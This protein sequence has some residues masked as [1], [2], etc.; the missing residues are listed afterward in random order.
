MTVLAALVRAYD[1]LAD[2]GLAPR[3][4]YSVQKIAYIIPLN[5]D[6]TVAGGPID[7]RVM[8]KRKLVAR[9]MAVPQPPK[10]TSGIAPNFLWDKTAYV[11]G[12]TAG[13]GKRLAAEH[14][15]FVSCHLDALADST[16]EGLV[17]LRRF[18]QAWQPDDFARLGWPEEMKDQN[19]AFALESERRETMI[20][21]RKAAQELWAR[22]Q[23]A[24]SNES[25][26]CLVTG[27]RAPVARLHPAIKGVWGAQ[28]SGASLVS[29][30]LDAFT[31]YGHEQ[32]DNAPVSEAAAFAYTTALNRFL[33]QGST[34]RLQVGDASTVFWAEAATREAAADAEDAF[35]A[36]MGAERVDEAAEGK[37]VGDM[38]ALIRSGQKLSALRPDLAEGVRFHV[39]G[40]APNAARL[41]VRFWLDDDFGVIATRLIDHQARMRIEPPPRDANP[42]FWR[43][44]IETAPLR[45]TDNILPNLAGDWLRA[46]LDGRPYP[47]TLLSTLLMR[48]RADKDVNGLRAAMLKALVIR[49]FPTMEVPVSLDPAKTD[50]GY[51]LGRLFAAYEYVQT[52]ALGGKVNATIRD[53]YYGTAS[54]TPR[55]V[56]PALQ[57]KAT[58][59]LARLRK[60]RPKSYVFVDSKIGAIFELA[61]PDRLF[62]PTLSAQ[63]QALFAVGYYHQRNDFYRG[64]D[65][66]AAEPKAIEEAAR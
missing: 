41:S 18:I 50:P 53:Q 40:L 59:H 47:L 45:K 26:I 13:E 49:N 46:I 12:V 63:Q 61:D 28:S 58:H 3:S 19:V 5:P 8:E 43:L 36:L 44:L 1:R 17:A 55:A 6:G 9:P 37:R 31:S 51:L 10:R 56:F 64:K 42:S 24:G 27:E 15:A 20:H 7:W 22:Q 39:L 33:A 4:G 48:L 60:D 66:P 29:F 23:S 54:A 30:N 52:Q 11:L 32:G 2:E 57:R 25:A 34:N 62:L 35:A 21:D 38:L 16:D 14:A 65:D